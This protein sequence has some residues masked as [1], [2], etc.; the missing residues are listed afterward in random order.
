MKKVDFWLKVLAVTFALGI[1]TAIHSWS[2]NVPLNIDLRGA[3]GRTCEQVT[4]EVRAWNTTMYTIPFTNINNITSTLSLGTDTSWTVVVAVRPEAADSLTTWCFA[5]NYWFSGGSK[6]WPTPAY[7]N[8]PTDSVV[9][10]FSIDGNTQLIS[11]RTGKQQ[12]DTAFTVQPYRQYLAKYK[13]YSPGAEGSQDWIWT[14]WTDTSGGTSVLPQPGTLNQCAI[15]SI[16]RNL[17]GQPMRYA[18]VTITLPDDVQDSCAGG[19]LFSRTIYT[20]TDGNGRFGISPVISVPKSLC[21]G[22]KP[23]KVTV[24]SRSPNDQPYARDF[25][26]PDSSS[27]FLRWR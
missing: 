25:V 17:A 4:L 5:Y 9:L 16:V 6:L 3:F 12:F 27:Y 1:L 15:W 23:I 2:V 13:I 22:N 21:V 11:K 20:E 18:K 14:F 10:D 24:S 19:L 7:W 8:F 26:I